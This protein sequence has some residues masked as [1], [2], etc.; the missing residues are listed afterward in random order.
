[1]RRSQSN[2]REQRHGSILLI[3]LVVIV[4]LSLTAY[5]FTS[6]MIV[7]EESARLLSRQVQSKYL[8]DSGIDF[9]RLLLSYNDETIREK[10]GIWNND[11]SFRGIP[12]GVDPSDPELIARFTIVAPIL[13]D[14]G[15]PSGFR[16]G[17]IDES[18]KINLN[19]LLFADNTS[20]GT[21]HAILMNLP[22][23]TDQIADAILDWIDADDDI[24]DFGTESNYY[25][26]QT[27]GY[28][29]KNGPMDSL[30]ELL[31]VRD[32]TPRL[33]FGM[34]TNRNGLLDESELTGQDS[35]GL[36]SEMLLGWMNY[37]T[38]Y[39]AESNLTEDGLPRVNLN[40][41]DLETLYTDLRA[42]LNEEWSQ[43][44]VQ[45]RISGPY[46]PEEDEEITEISDFEFP[47]L[48]SAEA[49]FT[50][51]MI[52]D[53]VD[54]YTKA[55]DGSVLASPI[56][57]PLLAQTL[58]ILLSTTTTYE[59]TT[60]PGRINLHQAPRRVLAAVPGMTEEYLELIIQYRE[61]ELSDP[62]LTDEYK[63]FETWIMVDPNV[64][65]DLETM[66]QMFPYVCAG[67]DVYSAEVVGFYDD[68]IG[69]SR[70]E[71]VLD[72][73]VPIPRIL[74]WR[75]KT[76]LQAGYQLDVLGQGYVA[77]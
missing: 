50:Y 27:P 34:D 57:T 18:S 60:I 45:Y 17:L 74:F 67:G 3:S 72:T 15:I 10:G 71:V 52:L 23:M 76:H 47:D 61:A 6:M 51:E 35:N 49:S 30:D 37:L 24:R 13:D 28:E 9:S 41:E 54:A 73:T 21:A 14:E 53:L 75:D 1:M 40:N 55:E 7:E 38:L 43:F 69:T 11:A 58:P 46:F 26:R 31:L 20:P 8:V 4:L 12:V 42:S 56:V 70:A 66:R 5:T 33:L 32:I 44:M 36:N 63:K 39:S 64:N 68:G 65:V 25:A 22:E 77:E 2:N 62:E 48:S 16:Y 59:G 19:T 29:C